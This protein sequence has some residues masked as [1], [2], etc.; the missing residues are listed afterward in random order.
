[1]LICFSQEGGQSSLFRKDQYKG[2]KTK[3]FR[4]SFQMYCLKR[5]RRTCIWGAVYILITAATVA[6]VSYAGA[7]RARPASRMTSPLKH[8]ALNIIVPDYSDAPC[9][10]LSRQLN[11]NVIF[12][13]ARSMRPFMS[14]TPTSIFFVLLW[15]V[16]PHKKPAE[17][18][19]TTQLAG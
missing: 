11:L 6:T 18:L 17:H 8:C 1:M 5:C 12:L 2:R 9:D 10:R 3:L 14:S 4:S 13:D 19:L 15:A 7:Q 16:A